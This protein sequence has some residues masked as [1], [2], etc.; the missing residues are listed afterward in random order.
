MAVD[1]LRPALSRRKLEKRLPWVAAAVLLVGVAALL[2]TRFS[3]TATPEPKEATGPPVRTTAPQKEIRFP[4][5]AW[6][7]AREFIFT[8]VA[9]KNRDEAYAITHKS[10]KAGM[11]LREWRRGELPVVQSDVA[12]ILKFNWK[13]TNYAYPRDAQINVVIIPSKGRP[14]TAQVGL[15]KVGHGAKARWLVSYFQAL[16]GVPVPTG[17]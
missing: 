10:L 3:N 4:P 11:S 14:W 12:Q 13:N 7:V 8:A 5:A 6:K 16:N 2:G 15:T 1:V 9:R 17:K